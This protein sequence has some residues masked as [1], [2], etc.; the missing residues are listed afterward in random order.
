[1]GRMTGR[2]GRLLVPILGGVAALAMAIAGYGFFLQ[3]QEHRMRLQ[4][5]AELAALFMERDA[6]QGQVASI[7]TA[8]AEIEEELSRVKSD[9]TDSKEQIAKAQQE[10]QQ[11]ATNLEQRQGEL[12]KLTQAM[13]QM[14]KEL[15]QVRAD[16]DQLSGQIA[17]LNGEHETLQKQ[18]TFAQEQ[19]QNLES[20]I[21]ELSRVPTVQLERVVVSS[22]EQEPS[23]ML[24]AMP[25]RSVSTNS[26][27][28]QVLVINR[29][30]DFV[31]MD[32]GKNQGLTVGQ[33]F[34]IVRGSEE[35]GKVK[36]EKVY[37]DLS[38]AAILPSTREDAIREGD[39]VR[40][41]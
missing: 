9:L 28:G 6:L 32:L 29:D 39:Q 5:E 40:A 41:L 10:Q 27:N 31:V 17:K 38:A 30:Y 8:K 34:Q 33:E 15:S 18:L 16:K 19:Q 37:D 26:I 13:D 24:A 36:V 12:S 21:S 3:S 11:L 35:I 23:A 4:K 25:T 14:M 1:M 20:K 2:Q 22:A 7:Q